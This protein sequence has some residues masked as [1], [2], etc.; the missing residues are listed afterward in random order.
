MWKVGNG[1]HIHIR[2]D[3]WISSL[4]SSRI[5]SHVTYD[6]NGR[7][8]DLINSQNRWNNDKLKN[9]FLPYEVDAIVRV[10]IQV[11]NQEDAR[12]QKFEKK[13]LLIGED[14]LLELS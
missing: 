7:V 2:R 13:G 12:Y 14:W 6:S 8:E 4:A 3:A 9:L 10:P 11:A 1:K 5:T